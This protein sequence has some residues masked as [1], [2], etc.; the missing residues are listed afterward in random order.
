MVIAGCENENSNGCELARS[1]PHHIYIIMGWMVWEGRGWCARGVDCMGVDGR[2]GQ[3]LGW[4][5]DGKAVDAM[6]C[7][8]SPR[9]LSKKTQGVCFTP[10]GFEK[11]AARKFEASSQKS[12][13]ALGTVN[14]VGR[15]LYPQ[16]IRN[17]SGE[18][19]RII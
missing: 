10:R 1:H 5:G 15:L 12:K 13:L 9:V 8:A 4:G 7:E 2:G 17:A 19:M 3:W 11:Q 14:N 6:R 18:A 16:R